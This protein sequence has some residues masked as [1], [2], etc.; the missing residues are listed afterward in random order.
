MAWR[1]HKGNN[2]LVLALK[3]DGARARLPACERWQVIFSTANAADVASVQLDYN[4]LTLQPIASL[5]GAN[6]FITDIFVYPGPDT[7]VV[8]NGPA[9]TRAL[10]LMSGNQLQA[11]DNE[12]GE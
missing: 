10:V 9:G 6:P 8:V 1:Q 4:G 3:V 2:P 7:Y 12:L 5:G 11:A